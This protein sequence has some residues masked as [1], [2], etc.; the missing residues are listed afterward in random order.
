MEFFYEGEVFPVKLHLIGFHIA[1]Y[2]Q[3]IFAFFILVCNRRTLRGLFHK[4]WNLKSLF[5]HACCM[6][7]TNRGRLAHTGGEDDQIPDE[8]I[9]L[10]PLM[11]NMKTGTIRRSTVRGNDFY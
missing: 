5:R 4:D 1:N 9:P 3:G 2:S 10:S 7:M 6:P 8:A 11:K